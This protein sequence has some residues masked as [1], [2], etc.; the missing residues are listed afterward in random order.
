MSLRKKTLLTIAL[1]LLALLVV[2]FI[3]SQITLRTTVMELEE[4]ES[5]EAVEQVKAEISGELVHMVRTAR[6]WS[7][8]DDSYVFMQGRFDGFI[9][10]HLAGDRLTNLEL[11]YM[12]FL[13]ETGNFIYGFGSVPETGEEIPV[14]ENFISFLLENNVLWQHEETEDYISGLM[15]FNEEVMMIASTPILTS[16]NEG[17]IEGSLILVHELDSKEIEHL[18]VGMDFIF[19]VGL[20]EDSEVYSKLAASESTDDDPLALLERKNDQTIIAHSIMEDVT[21]DPIILLTVE[22]PRDMYMR[23]KSTT[24]Q[25]IYLMMGVGVVFGLAM[26]FLLQKQVLSRLS[27]LSGDVA[28]IGASGDLTTRVSI[29]GNDELSSLG[30]SI[31]EMVASLE[32]SEFALIKSE[33][34]FRNLFETSLVGMWRVN[35]EDGKFIQANLAIAELLGYENPEQLIAE[36]NPMEVAV[37]GKRGQ[38]LNILEKEGEVTGAETTITTNDGTQKHVSIS[39]RLFPDKGYIEGVVTDIT[40]RKQVEEERAKLATAVDQAVEGILISDPEG[41]IQYVNPSFEKI[42]GFTRDESIDRHA[43]DIFCT[44]FDQD[45]MERLDN[46]F[47]QGKV[48]SD[49]FVAE[50]RDGTLYEIQSTVSPVRDESGNIISFVD[51]F[52]DITQEVMIEAQLRQAHKLEAIGQLAAGIAHEISTPTRFVGENTLF[53]GDS[54]TDI[55]ELLKKHNELFELAKKSDCNEK[56]IDEL[57][58]CT[59]NIDLDYLSV[60]IPKAVE[61]SLE[62]IERIIEI[63][64]AMRDLAHPGTREK[65]EID[66]NRAIESTITISRPEWKHV[67]IVETGLD[68]DLPKVLC[69][70]GEFNQVILNLVTNAAQAIGD[71]PEKHQKD[72]GLIR[73]ETRQKDDCVEILISDNGM[74]IPEEIQ[75]RVFD[76][77]FTTKKVGRGTGQGLAI[78]KS[79]IE[80]SGGTITFESQKG[81]G[82][83]FCLSLPLK[84]DLTDDTGTGESSGSNPASGA[85]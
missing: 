19:Q 39:C 83:T 79:L 29:D 10:S 52:R 4:I 70:A 77:F 15:S 34:H 1:T 46:N 32:E 71:A 50:R 61:Q 35:I 21:G 3:V 44:M 69:F 23:G 17:P 18:S 24:M 66:I 47:Q 73:I 2:L 7:S 74:G 63:V 82:T 37:P 45:S 81:V 26:M 30:V 5:R 72:P 75:D 65:V 62:G 76:L 85:R 6:A 43:R 68:P 8:Y 25:F 78:V 12:I 51:V 49:R 28:E 22:V 41:I 58:G 84:P 36:C 48:W 40:A 9:E 13:D 20:L 27:R 14:P 56:L 64:R 67:A 55:M 54:F 80:K 57:Q 42:T 59:D 53:I 31:N 11:D 60:E 33:E 38:L 16:Y